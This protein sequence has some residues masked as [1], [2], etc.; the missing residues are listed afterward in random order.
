MGL[1]FKTFHNHQRT[2]T[3]DKVMGYQSN[4]HNPTIH[5]GTD[6]TPIILTLST[7]PI[8]IRTKARDNYNLADWKLFQVLTMKWE[9]IELDGKNADEIDRVTR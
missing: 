7:N 8:K 1:D 4:I 6:H 2:G 9:N 5:R 3:P